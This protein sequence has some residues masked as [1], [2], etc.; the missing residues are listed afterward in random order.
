MNQKTNL[1]IIGGGVLGAFASFLNKDW[2]EVFTMETL[3]NI[4]MPKMQTT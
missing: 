3:T 4:Q 2:M 1:I